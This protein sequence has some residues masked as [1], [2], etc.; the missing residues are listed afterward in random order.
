MLFDAF[1]RLA[2]RRTPLPP[3]PAG[4]LRVASADLPPPLK[5]FREGGG[6]DGAAAPFWSPPVQIA[7]PPDRAEIEVEDGEAPACS[8]RPRAARCR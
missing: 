4:A 1:A 8:S 6:D 3:A 7:F 2:A 5:R